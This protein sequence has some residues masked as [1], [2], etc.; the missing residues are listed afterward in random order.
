MADALDALGEALGIDR[1]QQVIDGAR[2]E[3]GERVLL[4]RGDEYDPRR[5]ADLER[6]IETRPSRHPDVEECDIGR[7]LRRQR[8]GLVAVRRFADDLEIRPGGCEQLAQVRAHQR[9]VVSAV[10]LSQTTRVDSPVAGALRRLPTAACL[11][12]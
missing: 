5:L 4:V 1:L 11:C 12:R 2:V 3:R 8:H 9:F 6:R 7:E 10:L